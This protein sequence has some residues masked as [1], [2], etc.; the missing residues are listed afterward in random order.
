MKWGR[1]AVP[2]NL[3]TGHPSHRGCNDDGSLVFSS[4]VSTTYFV[5]TLLNN[6]PF[7][8]DEEVTNL[9]RITSTPTSDLNSLYRYG[10]TSLKIFSLY[11]V[12]RETDGRFGP[13]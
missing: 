9:K 12:H 1:A 13:I 5:S 8:F 3:S 4:S 2:Y 10:C 6:D 7:F 11:P